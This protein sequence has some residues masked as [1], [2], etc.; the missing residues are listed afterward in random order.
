MRI[1]GKWTRK[2]QNPDTF[3]KVKQSGRV[4]HACHYI[5]SPIIFH[6]Q[7]F[8]TQLICLRTNICRWLWSSTTGLHHTTV[9]IMG[10]CVLFFVNLLFLPPTPR[11]YTHIKM[12]WP[13]L[14]L[15]MHTKRVPI[16]PLAP[17]C[18]S[19][20]YPSTHKS[21]I[22]RIVASLSH[23]LHYCKSATTQYRRMHWRQ[24]CI[25]TN[26]FLPITLYTKARACVYG[27]SHH[28]VEP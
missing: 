17:S 16:P 21:C 25:A 10:D 7:L 15:W 18:N 14:G 3:C 23:T 19:H 9:N 11:L 8:N 4:P 2:Q 1:P 27:K 12:V 20:L 6:S 24:L 28:T 26:N 22:T 5:R 13:L